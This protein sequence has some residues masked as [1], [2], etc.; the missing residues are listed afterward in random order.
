MSDH[1]APVKI[2][3]LEGKVALVTGAAGGIASGIAN[4]FAAAGAQLV[5]ADRNQAVE[6]RAEALRAVA[7]R[8]FDYSFGPGPQTLAVPGLPPVSPMICATTAPPMPPM[9]MAGMSR[10]AL[11]PDWMVRPVVTM[12]PASA[13]SRIHHTPTEAT[14]V[15]APCSPPWA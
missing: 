14:A 6:E 9:T 12:R 11:P 3:S 13:T 4:A 15:L 10:P 2:F 7:G 5:L 1:L 8:R